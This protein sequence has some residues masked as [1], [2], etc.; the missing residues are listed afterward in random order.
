MSKKPILNEFWQ[1]SFGIENWKMLLKIIAQ[2]SVGMSSQKMIIL[3]A[4][5]PMKVVLTNKLH[6]V[7][8]KWACFEGKWRLLLLNTHALRFICQFTGK[9]LIISVTHA[10]GLKNLN[11]NRMKLLKRLMQHRKMRFMTEIN[12]CG[13]KFSLTLIFP[14]KLCLPSLCRTLCNNNWNVCSL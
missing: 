12:D 11:E 7:E 14:I 4:N 1:K 6:T 9:L 10:A 3:R 5:S 2:I 8:R 13:N